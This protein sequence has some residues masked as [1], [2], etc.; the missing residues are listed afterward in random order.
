MS[1]YMTFALL[2]SIV[3]AQ[4]TVM[5]RAA[6]GSAAPFLPLIAVVCWGI[7]RGPNAGLAWAI[8]IGLMLDQMSPSPIGMYT[9][10]LVVC[11]GVLLFG[12]RIL[13]SHSI[14]VPAALVFV[15]TFVYVLA[16][17]ALIGI[18]GGHVPWSP[19]TQFGLI[20]PRI[21]LNLLWFPAVFF[22]L[23]AIA[24]RIGGPRIGL[25]WEG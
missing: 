7:L 1:P 20:A 15:A 17:E 19:N 9:V 14:A 18:G 4:M 5:P 21:A 23:R 11:A 16:Q 24:R 10:P 2:V 13:L 8:V 25:G 12:R 22:P 3:W 6:L